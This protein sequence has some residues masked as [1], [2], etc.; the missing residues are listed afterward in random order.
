LALVLVSSFWIGLC[1]GAQVEKKCG[2]QRG[3][4]LAAAR[5]PV[6][7]IPLLRPPL[8]RA[9]KTGGIV[10]PEITTPERK[11][12]LKKRRKPAFLLGEIISPRA[13]AFVISTIG[14]KSDE[15]HPPCNR[16]RR[17]MDLTY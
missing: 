11:L 15:G 4:S 14:I 3:A 8:P 7:K 6:K 16:A 17:G 2:K 9:S 1:V 10:R 12:Q 5:Y 13:G